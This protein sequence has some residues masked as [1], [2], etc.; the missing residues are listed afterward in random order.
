[1]E[2]K[3]ARHLSPSAQEALRHRAV[4]AM[5]DG[6]SKAEEIDGPACLICH[7][8]ENDDDWIYTEHNMPLPRQS[9]EFDLEAPS[10]NSWV[11]DNEVTFEWERSNDPDRGDMLFYEVE[12]DTSP[13]FAQP[14]ILNSG[15]NFFY[16]FDNLQENQYY[17]W[18]VRAVDL[19]SGGRYSNSVRRFQT[20]MPQP[21]SAFQLLFPI[22]N[23]T[24]PRREDFHLAMLW[25]DSIDPD[26][27]TSTTYGVTVHV[28][29]DE[30]DSIYSFTGWEDTMLNM[31]LLR[32]LGLEHWTSHLRILWSVSAVSDGDT[33]E[34]ATPF[35]Y[36]IE[37][38]PAESSAGKN[39]LPEHFVFTSPYPN[40][41][42]SVS[43]VGFSIP[44]QAEFNIELYSTQGKLVATVFNGQ[45]NAGVHS[46]AIDASQLSGGV[47]F[48]RWS[49]EIYGQGASKLLLLR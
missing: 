15:A 10:H 21:P 37:P 43:H 40:P 1:M 14:M 39:V 26:P 42:N 24:I 8:H 30:I 29:V 18:R 32:T 47:Y 23:D 27:E 17:L 46:F 49:S 3:D 22:N 34:C 19:N 44:Q 20:A 36:T 4:K 28:E 45:I 33:T 31:P 48:L 7:E 5:V 25:E 41:F 2:L 16:A 35:H 12:L 13:E 9:N 38:Y 11:E 6:K